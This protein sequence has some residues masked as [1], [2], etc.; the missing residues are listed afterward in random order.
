MNIQECPKCG[1]PTVMDRNKAHDLNMVCGNKDENGVKCKY[2]Y[3][4]VEAELILGVRKVDTVDNEGNPI[5]AFINIGNGHLYF[6]S[7]Y[8]LK[9]FKTGLQQRTHDKLYH[10][11]GDPM[12][13]CVPSGFI[14][15]FQ[16]DICG[17]EEVIPC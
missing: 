12:A 1:K 9:R 4:D 10:K 7:W 3:T 8:C 16:K 11:I 13:G 5:S 15:D 14:I 17:N 6:H 2:V